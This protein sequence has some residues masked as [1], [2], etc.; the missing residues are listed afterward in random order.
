[1][2]KS[3]YLFLTL[4][5]F[6]LLI[7]FILTTILYFMSLR[8][9]NEGV[10]V[11]LFGGGDDG[12]FYWQQ[13]K[14]VANG[15]NW[16]KTSIYPLIIGNLLKITGLEDVYIIRIFNYIGFVF[17]VLVSMRLINLQYTCDLEIDNHKV[18]YNSKIKI[19]LFFLI[20]LSLHMNVYLSIYRDIW[21]YLFYLISVYL[22]SKILFYKKNNLFYILS[23]LFSFWMLSGFRDYAA[24]SFI[25]SLIVFFLYR[26][27]KSFNNSK[28]I[29]LLG[30]ILLAI[31]Y[32]FFIDFNVPLVNK[33]LRDVLN[34]RTS[35]LDSFSGGS[36]MWINLAQPNFILFLLNYGYS[37]IGNLIGPL[38][39]HISSFSTL[40]VFVFESVPI[41]IVLV[42]LFKKRHLFSEIQKYIM[43]HA[44][45]W[46]SLI[47]VSND[48]IGT[49]SR[50]RPISWILI[51]I[52]CSVVYE[53]NK[54][55]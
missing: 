25:L 44:G 9:G 45:I 29:F 41:I 13:A 43:L 24:L 53:K 18:I 22:S 21:I 19:L 6:L 8:Q 51:L 31:Y 26:K 12:F 47:A 40:L 20:Y 32:T 39:W 27:I 42:Y 38:P 4:F 46:I 55:K 5:Q 23:F 14:N 1:M 54:A 28:K 10:T 52:I 37:Y 50:L 15:S 11:N 36:Q 49:A 33:S 16:V 48:N 7:Y 35:S 3:K 2:R 34:Y 17:L 30:V